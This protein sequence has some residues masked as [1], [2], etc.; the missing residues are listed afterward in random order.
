MIST[1]LS[2][3]LSATSANAAGDVPAKPAKPRKI[4]EKV[5][6]TGSRVSKRICRTV[7]APK[8][9]DE[10]VQASTEKTATTETN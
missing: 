1:I 4:C 9:K 3:A 7:E 6:I 10:A 5:E 2:L 8:P